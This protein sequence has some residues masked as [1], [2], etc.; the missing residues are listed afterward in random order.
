MLSVLNINPRKALTKADNLSFRLVPKTTASALPPYVHNK[1]FVFWRDFK[2]FL[3][4]L[5]NN[6]KITFIADL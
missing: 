1:H 2:E 4:T 5:L 6:R 3:L